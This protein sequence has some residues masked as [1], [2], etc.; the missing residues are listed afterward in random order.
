MRTWFDEEEVDEYRDTVLA[1]V[2]LSRVWATRT[3]RPVPD[4]LALRGAC[5]HRQFFGDG[6]YARWSGRMLRDL[7]LDWFPRHCAMPASRWPQVVPSLHTW[8]DFLDAHGILDPRGEPL[9]ALHDAVDVLAA[10]FPAAMADTGRYGTE[11]LIVDAIRE[12][13]LDPADPAV[14]GAFVEDLNAGRVDPRLAR[15]LRFRSMVEAAAEPAGR[16]PRQ[17]PVAL[18]PDERLAADA[19]GSAVVRQLLRLVHWVGEPGRGLTQTGRLKPA[20]AVE[21][22]RLL[23]TDDPVPPSGRVRSADDL[24]R[25][26]FLLEWARRTHLVR[27]YRGRLVLVKAARTLVAAPLRLY[28]RAFAALFDLRD[29]LFPL[30]LGGSLLYEC[31]AEVLPEVLFAVYSLPEPGAARDRL[32]D[33]VWRVCV[34]R[35]V[36]DEGSPEA[37]RWRSEL[38]ADFQRVVDSL[39]RLGAAHPVPAGSDAGGLLLTPLGTWWVRNRLLAEGRRAPLIGELAAAD[40]HTLLYCLAEDY[41]QHGGRAE[42]ARWLAARGDGEPPAA[43]PLTAVDGTAHRAARP[44]V[45]DTPAALAARA[46]LVDALHRTPL[47]TRK[48]G[49]LRILTEDLPEGHRFAESLLDNPDLGPVALQN[50]LETGHCTTEGLGPAAGIMGLAESFA[51]LLELSGPEALAAQLAGQD[52]HVTADVL[53]AIASSGHPCAERVLA[54]VRTGQQQ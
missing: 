40:A 5:D 3:G 49:L 47:R 32:D 16:E 25:L 4:P 20:D 43:H 13:G 42:L 46:E 54:A 22:A 41:D 33:A 11:K 14:F 34:Q 9:P 24:P 28:E 6:H 37:P 18:P 1:L 10:D 30:E 39:V 19:A 36:I 52:Q 29:V 23:G 31:L 44:E 2:R 35:F 45:P 8:L 7:L 27:R 53:A 51:Q 50:L 21:L 15:T 48:A 26:A 17:L 38:V 12:R